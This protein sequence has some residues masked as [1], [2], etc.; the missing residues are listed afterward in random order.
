MPLCRAGGGEGVET[1]AWPEEEVES[2]EGGWADVGDEK[3][4]GED[5]QGWIGLA[6]GAGRGR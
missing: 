2:G 5:D 3:R 4:R 6:G 1:A